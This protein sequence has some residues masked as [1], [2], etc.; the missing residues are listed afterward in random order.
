[1][2]EQFDGP[3]RDVTL[4]TAETSDALNLKVFRGGTGIGPLEGCDVQLTLEN[5]TSSGLVYAFTTPG[6]TTPS[7]ATVAV[8]GASGFIEGLG[9]FVP[10]SKA[11]LT[12]GGSGGNGD[13]DVNTNTGVPVL[14]QATPSSTWTVGF[15]NETTGAVS[16]P[17][18]SPISQSETQG[19]CRDNA[20]N[21]IEVGLSGSTLTVKRLKEDGTVISTATT[22]G[23]FTEAFPMYHPD[24][25][26]VIFTKFVI[27]GGGPSGTYSLVAVD[28]SGTVSTVTVT[29]TAGRSL[30][31]CILPFGRVAVVWTT[32]LVLWI[33]VYDMSNGTLMWQK[34]REQ[35]YPAIL[36][37]TAY[38]PIPMVSSSTGKLIAGFIRNS[39]SSNDGFWIGV[40][41]QLTGAVESSSIV[42]P[43]TGDAING[44]DWYEYGFADSSGRVYIPIYMNGG[45]VDYLYCFDLADFSNP[46]RVTGE[47]GEFE[48]LAIT[49]NAV[50]GPDN[51]YAGAGIGI[52]KYALGLG[53]TTALELDDGTTYAG[54]S[55]LGLDVKG[56]MAGVVFQKAKIALG[57]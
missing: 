12:I 53:S 37:S 32:S 33:S 52:N 9:Q 35:F 26:S 17:F 19:F 25:D 41:N 50:Y 42:V 34:S 44:G 56:Y 8:A 14:L 7:G 1:M 49:E 43:N 48:P 47:I 54:S 55:Q 30:S 3:K 16:N 10:A 4:P 57:G 18:T 45:S 21:L 22:T 39:G 28:A 6:T 23:T 13:P 2:V 24:L 5:D 38:I 40:I 11:A 29:T 27:N 51:G 31:K 15:F 36:S 20:G 46:T